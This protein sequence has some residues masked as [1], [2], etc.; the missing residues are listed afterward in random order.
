MTQAYQFI[1]AHQWTVPIFLFR[2]PAEVEAYIFDLARDPARVREVSG[3]PGNAFIALG[4]DPP[5]GAVLRFLAGEAKW[6]EDPLPTIIHNT[7][8]AQWT[9]PADTSRRAQAEGG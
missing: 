8:L 2:Y 5:S 7:L 4:I 1:G 3:R 6:L 9:A